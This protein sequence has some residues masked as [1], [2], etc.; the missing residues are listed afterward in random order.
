MPKLE[1]L[2]LHS[3]YFKRQIQAMINVLSAL[4]RN[5]N[6]WKNTCFTTDFIRYAQTA[7]E[8]RQTFCSQIQPITQTTD[9]ECAT[10][11]LLSDV[12]HCTNMNTDFTDFRK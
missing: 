9:I 11:F 10:L 7:R 3:A 5:A 2:L 8:C 12:L 1:E 6:L 4:L